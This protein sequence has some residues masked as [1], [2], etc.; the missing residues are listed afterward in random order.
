MLPAALALLAPADYFQ[1]QTLAKDIFAVVR[2]EP[3]GLAVDC[4]VLLIVNEKDVVMVDANIGPE[5]ATATLDAL[6]KITSKP[7][8]AIIATH[9][10]DDHMGGVA[11]I[12]ARFP[13]V[14]LI[15]HASATESIINLLKP[16]REGMIEVAPQMTTWLKSHLDK[17]TSIEGQPIDD[18]QRTSYASD[19]RL[20][21]RYAKEMPAVRLPFPTR[22][23]ND[24]LI[25]KRDDRE[26]QIL[27]L[28]EGHTPAD[29]VVWLPKERIAAVG[30]LVCYPI[31]LV[32][33]NQSN[34]P[35][36]P[37]TLNKIKGLNFKT[38]LP[39]H[40]PVMTHTKYLD[41]MSVF[42]SAITQTV[43]KAI[44]QHK[45]LAEIQEEN[46]FSDQKTIFCGTST[47]RP[48]LFEQYLRL[49][50]IESAF[51]HLTKESQARSTEPMP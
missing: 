34:V 10:H 18:E 14:E 15:A 32:G 35:A 22:T 9:Y 40:G 45:E 21:E 11:T 28:G 7:V 31:P 2:K 3:P 6:A 37:A 5:S 26:I 47:V 46:A 41:Q 4:N 24:S 50:S 38:L 43:Q 12:R 51:R 30:D 48:F 33:G 20:A 16:A 25:L 13:N 23:V 29:L 49:P 8:S 1:V 17:N 27:H 44:P 42:F 36:W 19:I 39:G